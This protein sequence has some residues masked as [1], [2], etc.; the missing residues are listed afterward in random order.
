M[1]ESGFTKL[2]PL[3]LPCN[4]RPF[5]LHRAVHSGTT[6][7]ESSVVFG[8]SVSKSMSF[9]KP[10][11]LPTELPQVFWHSHFKVHT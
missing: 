11:L 4:I 10:L 8:L 1:C 9:I 7:T 3:G 5:A 6:Q 2:F